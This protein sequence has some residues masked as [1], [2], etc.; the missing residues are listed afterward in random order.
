MIALIVADPIFSRL[1][2][3]LTRRNNNVFE[4]E[5]RLYAT[6]PG[7]LLF[8]IGTVGWGWG[9]QVGT[10]WGGIAVFFGMM[11][12]GAVVYNAGVIGNIQPPSYSNIRIHHR[13]TS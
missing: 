4:P 9:S 11:L 3:W 1:A 6:I 2:T 13:R 12:G 8:V 5:F 10:P 7:I